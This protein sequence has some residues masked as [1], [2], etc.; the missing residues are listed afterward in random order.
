MLTDDVLFSRLAALLAPLQTDALTGRAVR[1][2]QR[3][4]QAVE[5]MHSLPRAV[6]LHR[7][8][9]LDLAGLDLSGLPLAEVWLSRTRLSGC[10]FARCDLTDADFREANLNGAVLTAATLRG[11]WMVRANLRDADLSGTDL[12]DADLRGADLRGADLRGA[13]R[14]GAAFTDAISDEKTA[15]SDEPPPGV[16]CLRPGLSAAGAD[17]SEQWLSRTSATASAA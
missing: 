9:T 1:D 13:T 7:L 11:A 3:V 16:R 5:L 14:S 2:P 15:W 12:S 10:R 6:W 8:R 17:L 4:A